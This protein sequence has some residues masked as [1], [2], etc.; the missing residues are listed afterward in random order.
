MMSE[1]NIRMVLREDRKWEQVVMAEVLVPN[2]V[3]N[4][5]DIYTVESIKEFA[6]EYARQGY[7]LDVEHSQQDVNG[8]D[9]YVVESFLV[10]E[11]DP[12]FIA[13]SWV[14]AVKIINDDLWQ[15]ILDGEING[16]SYEAV[17]S[18]LPVT[19]T[20]ATTHTVIGVTAPHPDDGHTH[21][22][23]ILVDAQHNPIAGG[24]GETNGHSHTISVHTVT[25]VADGHNHRFQVIALNG[26]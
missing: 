5:G 21:D 13:G 20:L 9:Y 1:Q 18:M 12:D 23:M 17:V 22:Y 7:G 15:Q 26:E 4:W 6:Y 25:D 14:V 16:F 24:T 11:G 10:R 3:N 8:V 2:V 19:V